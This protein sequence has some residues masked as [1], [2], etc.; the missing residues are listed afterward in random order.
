MKYSKFMRALKV[1]PFG[2]QN[3]PEEQSLKGTRW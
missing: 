1:Y 3:F 2:K